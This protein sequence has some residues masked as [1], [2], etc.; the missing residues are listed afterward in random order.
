MKL[1][2]FRVQLAVCFFCIMCSC[3]ASAAEWTV[4]QLMQ[5]LASHH[6]GRATFTETTYLAMLKRPVESSGELSFT[7][8]DYLQKTTLVPKREVLNLRGD[9]ISIE[10]KGRKHVLRLS[11]YPQIAAFVDSIRGTLVGDHAV[12]A[13]AYRMTLAGSENNWQLVLIPNANAANGVRQIAITGAAGSVAS[14]E[15][16][17]TDGDHSVMRIENLQLD[18]SNAVEHAP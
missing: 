5:A 2:N 6:S 16:M 14:I 1:L 18:G 17:Q 3:S 12:L 4:E 9:E 11:D 8:P 13:N 10:R 7:A 15:I